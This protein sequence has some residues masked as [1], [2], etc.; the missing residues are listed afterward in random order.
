MIKKL[1]SAEKLHKQWMQEPEYA[2]AVADLEDDFALA[3]AM[4]KVRSNAGLTQQQVAERMGTSRPNIVRLERGSHMPSTRTLLQFATATGHRARVE[5]APINRLIVSGN[6][7][8][9]TGKKVASTASKILHSKT[10]SKAEK[11]VAAS[12]LTQ[13]RSREVTGKAV[14]S[15]AS[16]IMADP[17]ASKAAKSVAA[18]ALTQKTAPRKK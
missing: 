16:K 12:V 1:V 3:S 6:K 15:K 10:A 11:S 18:L 9:S 14:A 17:K 5:F 4:I 2:R 7:S 13:S 8:E